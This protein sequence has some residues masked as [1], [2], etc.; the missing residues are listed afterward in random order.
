[1]TAKM[2]RQTSSVEKERISIT[3]VRARVAGLA[4]GLGSIG[5]AIGFLN[6]NNEVL[7][8]EPTPTVIRE[9]TPTVTFHTATPAPS[10]T[11]TPPIVVTPTLTATVIREATPTVTFHTAT[12]APSET[13]TKT[14]TAT[15]T[16]EAT[17]TTVPHTPTVE[18]S[19]TP[20]NTSTATATGTKTP[21][22]TPSNTPTATETP[23]V[24]PGEGQLKIVKF[25]DR[26][27]D[28]QVPEAGEEGLIWEFKVDGQGN[29]LEDF[30]AITL[31]DGTVIE[32][33]APGVYRICEKTQPNWLATIDE[34]VERI[35]REGQITEA[36]FGNVQ[37]RPEVS[38]TPTATATIAKVKTPEPTATP[39]PE[40]TAPPN[41]GSGGFLEATKSKNAL[42]AYAVAGLSMLGGLTYKFGKR[43]LEQ[44]SLVRVPFRRRKR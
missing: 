21:E 20:T 41:A 24:V 22:A 31:G 32:S 5:L 43:G 15:V 18:A 44:E 3:G 19:P 13:P 33:V 34:C 30:K 7:A 14:P 28:G 4:V 27:G 2:E 16:R 35:V 25:H 40:V 1:M 38:V 23:T 6:A 39:T 8:I 42:I 10:E 36:V 37:V 12:P 29:G 11:P 17:P 26:D 9:A